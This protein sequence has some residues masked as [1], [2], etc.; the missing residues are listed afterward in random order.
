MIEL[1]IKTFLLLC[2]MINEESFERVFCLDG[3]GSVRKRKH[4]LPSVKHHTKCVGII[5]LLVVVVANN[6]MVE[7]LGVQ[8]EL[9][10]TTR[11]GL[12]LNHGDG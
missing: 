5:R 11:D 1:K 2:R 6:G 3:Q 7:G 9:V 10:T 12:K 4:N 8:S